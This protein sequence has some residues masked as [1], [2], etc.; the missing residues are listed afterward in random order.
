[1]GGGAE[2][3]GWVLV[4]AKVCSSFPGHNRPQPAD[5][6]LWQEVLDITRLLVLEQ[7]V[8]EDLEAEEQK[9][10]LEQLKTVLEM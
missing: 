2:T 8:Q 1:M 3:W 10:K 9:S 4:S 5:L 6:C 7:G